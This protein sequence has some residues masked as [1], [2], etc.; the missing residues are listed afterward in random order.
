MWLRNSEHEYQ[1]LLPLLKLAPYSMRTHNVLLLSEYLGTTYPREV[2]KRFGTAYFV[3]PLHASR[4]HLRIAS[5][6]A[7]LYLL[8][9]RMLTQRFT[10]CPPLVKQAFVRR[11]GA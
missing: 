2:E 4:S 3:Y 8:L 11:T 6:A 9:I 5:V 1:L 7:A 10:T